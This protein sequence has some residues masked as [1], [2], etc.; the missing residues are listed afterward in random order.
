MDSL[1]TGWAARIPAVYDKRLKVKVAG[2][3]DASKINM[4]A[5]VKA[6]VTVVY[7]NEGGEMV[8]SYAMIRKIY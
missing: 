8:P 7:K 5:S 4:G 3:V 1:K 2:A 6:D